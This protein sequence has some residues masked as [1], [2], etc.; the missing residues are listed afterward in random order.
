M[1]ISSLDSVHRNFLDC[2]LELS[3]SLVPE[4]SNQPALSMPYQRWFKF[5]EAFAPAFVVETIRALP[6]EPRH[7]LDPF[8]GSGTTAL[9]CQFL[10][11]GSTTIET[12]P[13]LADLI[14]S[15]LISYDIGQLRQTFRQ[16]IRRA[17]KRKLSART[18]NH[19][20]PGSPRTFVEPGDGERWVFNREVAE[21]V[22]ALRSEIDEVDDTTCRRFLRVMLGCRLI[23]VS[24]VVVNGKGRRYRSSWKKRSVTPTDVFA[25]FE[26]ACLIGFADIESFRRRRQSDYAVLRGDSRELIKQC[27][28]ADFILTSPPYPNSFDYTDIYNVELW[29]LGYLTSSIDNH[30][31]RMRTLRSHVQIAH[32]KGIAECASPVLHS[33]YRTLVRHRDK[34][35][36]PRIPEMICLYFE[37]LERVLKG[38]RA[39]LRKGGYVVM[40]LGNSRYA[41]V[42][43]DVPRILC[44]LIESL[45]FELVKKQ[46]VRSMRASS[47]QGGRQVLT[48]SLLWL[49]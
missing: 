19:S 11:I 25:A 31:L 30:N 32:D 49:K 4:T 29:A 46:S 40:A 9:T 48:E 33:T 15:K 28:S 5:K 23:E 44:D 36:N 41:G 35:W 18:V 26:E 10:G 13:F 24:N 21:A 22:L 38:C 12:N 16:V 14:E 17:K 45:G 42:V 43:I 47:Q 20:F 39:V 2:W 8:G 6:Y 34:L 7:C 3:R 37:D 1:S 27:K